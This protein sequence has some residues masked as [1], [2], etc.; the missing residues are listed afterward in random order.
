M[1]GIS[2]EYGTSNFFHAFCSIA[3]FRYA[4]QLNISELSYLLRSL[5]L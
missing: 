3:C 2:R 1:I 5:A 4:F